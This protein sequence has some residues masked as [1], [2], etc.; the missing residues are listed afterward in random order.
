MNTENIILIIMIFIIILII[1]H[2][3]KRINEG[4]AEDAVQLFN[5]DALK[6]VDDNLNTETEKL[7][8]IITKMSAIKDR[9]NESNLDNG[10][11]LAPLM[12]TAK[13]TK[14]NNEITDRVQ[15]TNLT[16]HYQKTK[17][18]VRDDRQQNVDAILKDD[19]FA[20]QNEDAT[21]ELTGIKHYSSAI[22]DLT[23]HA[24]DDTYQIESKQC[25]NGLTKCLSVTDDIK[26][27]MAECNVEDNS[28]YFNINEIKSEYKCY[29]MENEDF[30][31]D[32]EY[33]NE[34]INTY[35]K[36]DTDTFTR[37]YNELVPTALKITKDNMNLLPEEFIAIT[38]QND[39]NTPK[40]C[41]N[42]DNES[43]SFIPCNLYENQ[44]FTAI[45]K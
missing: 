44:R 2:K 20:K 27:K 8:T 30:V 38:L 17:K 26:S 31:A 4:F 33:C 18:Q 19:K 42:I 3:Y 35:L 34:N 40:L 14:L 29:N 10:T 21:K 43:L 37:K 22:F 32:E 36:Q 39:N 5:A 11:T 24:T 7:N 45:K 13:L 12:D 9:T 16:K 41:L 25:G 28:Q 23:K 15:N 1:C 6:D